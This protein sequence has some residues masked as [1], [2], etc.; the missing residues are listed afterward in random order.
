MT[1]PSSAAPG[2][3]VRASVLHGIG[4]VRLERRAVPAPGPGE[5][6]VE[7]TAVGVCGS[8]THYYTHGRIGPFSVD[9]PLV[10]GH[11]AAGRIVAVGD[12]VAPDRVGSRVSIEP[13]RPCRRCDQCKAGR[14]NLCP[15]MEFF[16]TPPID[17]AFAE[18]VVIADDFAHDVPDSVSDAAA[19]LI[20]PL[21]VGVWACQKAG[22]GAG[23]RVLVTG[24]GPVGVITAQV[25]RALGASEVHI[26]DLSEERLRFALEHG[27]THTHRADAPLD[28]LEVDAFIDASGAQSAIRAG[29]PAV[30]P[31]GVVVL[32]G[33]GADDV[34]LPMALLQNREL[35][36]TGVFR[37]ANTW[38]LAIRLVAEER[39]DLDCLVTE[40]HGLADAESALTAGERPGNMKALVL[41][42]E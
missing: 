38:P 6:L 33:L 30:R 8:D 2:T 32:V 39:V 4:D 34:L 22:V 36:L 13:Q 7:V 17:G 1:A 24:A 14:Y 23:S 20:E 19:A 31:A 12:G 3:T 29:I 35:V 25:A 21:S 37:Y 9:A 16:A 41:P 15:E 28:H 40:R 42:Q 18:R 11:E 10:L 27:A 5:V 26:S